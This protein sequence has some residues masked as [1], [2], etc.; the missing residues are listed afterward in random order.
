MNVGDLATRKVL[1]ISPRQSLREAGRVMTERRVG[2]AVVLGDGGSLVG[3]FTERDMLQAVGTGIDVDAA[4]VEEL[5]TREVV[6]VGPHWEVYEAAAEMADRHIR[7]LVVTEDGRIVGILSVRDLL[8]A[9]QRVELGSGNWAV[10]RDPVTFSVRERRRLQR[11]LLQLRGGSTWEFVEQVEQFASLHQ[12]SGGSTLDL[13]DLIGHLVG[14]WSFDIP[15]PADGEA[16]R[17]LPP[18]DYQRL[19]EAVLDDLPDLQRVVHPAPGWRRREIR[20]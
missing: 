1:A 18:D 11:S 8:I 12:L 13:D 6:T 20:R 4:R 5:M 15:L 9:G 17:A 3:I 19:R 16:L 2:S 14:S 10:F 7:H